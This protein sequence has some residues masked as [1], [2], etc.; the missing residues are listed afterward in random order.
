MDVRNNEL[1]EFSK[2]AESPL[3]LQAISA[4]EVDACFEHSNVFFLGDEFVCSTREDSIEC[5]SD[6]YDLE[7]GL[8]EAVQEIAASL[9]RTPARRA[10]NATSKLT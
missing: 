9:A 5:D 8:L 2:L 7:L 10:G 6:F 3:D 4:Q 1:T